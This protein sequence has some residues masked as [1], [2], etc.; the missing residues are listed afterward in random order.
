MNSIKKFVDKITQQDVRGARELVL[1]ISEARQIRDDLIKLL[2][3]KTSTESIGDNRSV[4][5]S[6]GKF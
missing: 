3:D 1:S 5:I 4:V 6:G 2:L